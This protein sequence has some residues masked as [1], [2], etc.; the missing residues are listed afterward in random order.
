[1]TFLP[2]EGSV[3]FRVV[4]ERKLF[5]SLRM[6]WTHDVGE[7]SFHT[8]MCRGICFFGHLVAVL[9][10]MVALTKGRGDRKGRAQVGDRKWWRD[11]WGSRQ[12]GDEQHN[13]VRQDHWYVHLLPLSSL[14]QDLKCK[15]HLEILLLIG[16]RKQKE[17]VLFSYHMS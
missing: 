17:K 2:T 3:S 4:G 14:N 7:V 12:P 5:Y 13:A 15:Y 8:N 9:G 6:K 11:R 1:M 16:L 10:P